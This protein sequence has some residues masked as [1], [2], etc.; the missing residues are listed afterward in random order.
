[1]TNPIGWCDETWNPI[2]GCTP[3]SEGCAN[4]YAAAIPKRFGWPGGF[5]VMFHP[6]RLDYPLHWKKPQRIFVGSM[7]D[8]FHDNVD[9]HDL[10]AVLEVIDACSQHTFQ[11]LTKR[12]ANLEHKLYQVTVA[13][14]CR[15]LGGGVYIP[16]LHLGV[17]VE[18]QK[19]C[20]RIAMLNDIPA[21]K[22]FVSFEPL[23]GPMVVPAAQMRRLDQIII[24]GETKGA[25]PG[26]ECKL[27]WVRRL[28]EQAQAENVAVWVKKLHSDAKLV[29]NLEDMPEWARLRQLPG[30][31]GKD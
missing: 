23:L 10:D 21:A 7:G 2:T 6:D 1:M 8:L 18:L 14:G 9:T 30:D 31:G 11:M 19:Y 20:D 22:R 4:C 5:E 12:A 27:E 17:T 13:H 28:I 26:R 15:L 24:G 16:N 3:V 29:K 25:Y